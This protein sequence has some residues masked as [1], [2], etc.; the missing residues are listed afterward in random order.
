[1][2]TPAI[3]KLAVEY[4][5]P[6]SC[7]ASAVVARSPS[8]SPSE[9]KTIEF[10]NLRNGLIERTLRVTSCAGAAGRGSDAVM[11]LSLSGLDY[12]EKRA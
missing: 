6:E 2:K 8:Q 5:P 3:A 1:M 9:E 7:W 10:H 12:R 11:G 4:D